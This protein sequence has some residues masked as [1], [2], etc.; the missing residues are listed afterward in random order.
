MP[1]IES[2]SA[3]YKASVLI[4]VSLSS[5][6]ILFNFS[7]NC[8]VFLIFGLK[9]HSSFPPTL[10]QSVGDHSL[11]YSGNHLVLD[12]TQAFHMYSMYLQPIELSFW[13]PFPPHPFLCM[14]VFWVFWCMV[15]LRAVSDSAQGLLVLGIEPGSTVCRAPVCW[16]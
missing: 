8:I 12:S 11:W 4:S 15:V 1:R 13:L 6:Q 2:R 7:L 3:M 14:G 5:P 10:L 9:I 16:E